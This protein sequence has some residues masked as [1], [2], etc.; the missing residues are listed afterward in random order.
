MERSKTLPCKNKAQLGSAVVQEPQEGR[1]RRIAAHVGGRAKFWQVLHSY[2][3]L[4][5]IS[6]RTT[7]AAA[8]SAHKREAKK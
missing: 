8:G 4:N 3:N 5:P 6:L 1:R 7:A 2:A